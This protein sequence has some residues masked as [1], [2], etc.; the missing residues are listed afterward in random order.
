MFRGIF[1][2]GKGLQAEIDPLQQAEYLNIASTAYGRPHG[3]LRYNKHWLWQAN[4][5]KNGEAN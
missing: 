2:K 5:P 4:L 1:I 3:K